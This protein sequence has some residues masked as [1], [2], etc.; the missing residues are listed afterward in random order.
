MHFH[1]QHHGSSLVHGLAWPSGAPNVEQI[2]ASADG[3]NTA[4]EEV[5]TYVDAS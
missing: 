2:V 4:K 1:W 5:V 3:A